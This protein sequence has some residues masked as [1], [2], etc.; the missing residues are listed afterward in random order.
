MYRHTPVM[1]EEAMRYLNPQ[2]GEIFADC[3]L[4]GGGYTFEISKLV[5]KSGKV[6]AIDLDETAI[7]HAKLKAA[8]EGVSNIIIS[9][10]NFR[11][12]QRIVKTELGGSPLHCLSGIVFDLG[13]S[14]AQLEDRARGFSFLQDAPLSMAFGSLIAGDKTETIVNVTPVSELASILRDFGEERYALSIARSIAKSRKEKAITTTKQLVEAIGRGV[15]GAYKR[16]RIH[17]ATRTFQALRI[18]TND[19]LGNLKD[20]LTNLRPLLKPGARIVGISFHSLEDRI[21]KHF[22]REESKNCLCP[23]EV[24]VCICGHRAW[25][26]ILTK[27]ALTPSAEEIRLNPRARSA[28]LRAALVINKE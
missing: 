9:H 8:R 7:N 27:K 28:K 5:G 1:L 21:V 20:L 3:T 24:P 19:E 17:F 10:A 12:L 25:L 26:K 14:S 22:F 13:L 18:A 6:I 2:P 15:P 4:G 16:Q 23:P 11:D